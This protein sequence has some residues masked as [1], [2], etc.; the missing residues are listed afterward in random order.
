MQG[1]VLFVGG[2]SGIDVQL[3]T[4]LVASNRLAVIGVKRGTIEQLKSLMVL[5]ESGHVNKKIAL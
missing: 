5:L 1:G 4:K 3:P 2:L